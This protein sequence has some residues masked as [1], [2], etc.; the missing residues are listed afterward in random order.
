MRFAKITG[1]QYAAEQG[2]SFWWEKERVRG[3]DVLSFGWLHKPWIGTRI[4]VGP[5]LVWGGFQAHLLLRL[6]IPRWR[7]KERPLA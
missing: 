1:P 6:R 2:L 3:E 5:V 7:R 4:V